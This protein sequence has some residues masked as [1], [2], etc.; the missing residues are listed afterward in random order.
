M[1]TVHG[2]N[3]GGEVIEEEKGERKRRAGKGREGKGGG[4]NKK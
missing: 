3:G 4:E 2:A 1:S